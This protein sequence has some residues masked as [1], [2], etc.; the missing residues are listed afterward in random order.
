MI[1]GTGVDIVEVA[2]MQQLLQKFSDKLLQKILT[3]IELESYYLAFHKINFLSKR[4]AAKEAAAKALGTGIGKVAFKDIEIKHT[5]L[6]KP[7]LYLSGEAK[8]VAE[9]LQVKA[10]HL[11]LSDERNYVIAFVILEGK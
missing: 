10:N 2:R 7:E 6:G 5:Q 11:S 1:I 9:Q 4:F 3:P 8:L